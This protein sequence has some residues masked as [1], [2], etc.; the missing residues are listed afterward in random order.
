MVASY[1]VVAVGHVNSI[2]EGMHAIKTALICWG[3]R[4]ERSSLTFLG[5]SVCIS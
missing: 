3:Y 2:R 5:N 4:R 1:V